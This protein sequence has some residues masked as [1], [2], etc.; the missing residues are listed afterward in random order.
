M[1]DLNPKEFLLAWHLRRQHRKQRNGPPQTW[2]RASVAAYE[3]IAV[4]ASLLLSS[5]SRARQTG[6]MLQKDAWDT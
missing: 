2:A 1:F 5:P 4:P 6:G 3:R